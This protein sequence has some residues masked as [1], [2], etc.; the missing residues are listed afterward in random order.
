MTKQ[1]FF[2]ELTKELSGLSAADIKNSLEYY[3]EMIADR[4]E[5]GMSED[6]AIA[7]LGDVREISREII[8]NMP[9]TKV[10]KSKIKPKRALKVWEIVCIVLGSPIWISLLA[11]MLSLAI[12]VYAVIWS[13][14]ISVLAVDIGALGGGALMAFAAIFN[15]TAVPA[16]ATV[17]IGLGICTMGVG[18]FF[19][20]PTLK[21]CKV[22]VKISI[23]ITRGIKIMLVG[24]DKKNEKRN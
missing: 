1:N 18:I 24:K 12:T 19:L 4:V 15:L 10:L 17:A 2:K 11:V 13:I 7:E 8:G 5:S 16:N 14:Y 3:S 20:L 21:L 9:M 6:E 23:A 22:F